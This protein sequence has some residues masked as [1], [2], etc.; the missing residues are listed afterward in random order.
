M[1]V[2][3]LALL[4]GGLLSVLLVAG[5]GGDSGAG[6]TTAPPLSKAEFIKRADA[7]CTQR[8]E[9]ARTKFFAYGRSVAKANESPA[10]REE[11]VTTVAETII[12]PELRQQIADVRALGAPKGDEGQVSAILSAIEKGIAKAKAHP[13]Q[14]IEESEILLE[15]AGKLA[16]AYGLQVCGTG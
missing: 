3:I 13:K 8:V 9:E 4:A 1:R 6:A 7:A 2:R 15:P 11:H 16:K 5:C 10:E 14:A 12:V